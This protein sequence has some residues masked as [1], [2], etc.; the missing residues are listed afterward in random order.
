MSLVAILARLAEP[1][2]LGELGAKPSAAFDAF[3]A[4]GRSWS[5]RSISQ[6]ALPP[7]PALL[8][9][10]VPAAMEI[11]AASTPAR[12]DEMLAPLVHRGFQTRFP[13]LSLAYRELGL[14][15]RTMQAWA[16][17]VGPRMRL[18][19]RIRFPH[20][21][22]HDRPN[23]LA[24]LPQRLW[25]DVFEQ[26]FAHFLPG[27]ETRLRRRFCALALGVLA[28][29]GSYLDVAAGLGLPRNDSVA[30]HLNELLRARH[31]HI[32]FYEAIVDAARWLRGQDWTVDYQARRRSLA[33]LTMID[34]EDWAW[35]CWA[36]GI[37]MDRGRR[38]RHSSTW[39]WRVLTGGEPA[40]AP[41]FARDYDLNSEKLTYRRFVR[42]HLPILEPALVALATR[43]LQRRGLSGPVRAD[44]SGWG[45]CPQPV[46]EDITAIG[47]FAGRTARLVR[48]QPPTA[49][50]ADR[51]PFVDDLV[52]VFGIDLLATLIGVTRRMVYRYQDGERRPAQT[53]QLRLGHLSDIVETL[54]VTRTDHAILRWFSET[55]PEHCPPAHML[56]G[57]WRPLD[58]G[59]REAMKMAVNDS[60]GATPKRTLHTTARKPTLSLVQDVIDTFGLEDL[61]A[62]TEI[63]RSRLQRYRRG[64]DWPSWDT[65]HQFEALLT[66]S[67]IANLQH[68][69][70]T[71]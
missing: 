49:A 71:R 4:A 28:T 27:V 14:R 58:E 34:S 61:V 59:P 2:E 51:V 57:H 8:A 41:T 42:N 47:V 62:R 3:V 45:P 20:L 31:Q 1:E 38:Q 15:D 29:K 6:S 24:L 50:P 56:T 13:Y 23:G 67:G 40:L 26:R 25:P 10:V 70:P 68:P 33:D 37:Y 22:P 60:S 52:E 44:L 12:F 55:R 46:P 65:Q 64:E 48:Q 69:L 16:R 43:E 7:D 36:T 30:H 19:A 53:I 18:T 63:N 54:R 11:L 17:I 5:P 9:A 66:G 32:A 21:G 39:I 35:A